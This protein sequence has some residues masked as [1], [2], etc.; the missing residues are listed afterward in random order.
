MLGPG[1]KAD[2]ETGPQCRRCRADLSLLFSLEEQRR[3]VLATA[4]QSA[5]RLQAHELTAA[6]GHAHRLRADADSLRLLALGHLLRRGFA[7]PRGVYHRP[8]R[9]SGGVGGLTFAPPAGPT[10]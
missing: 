9:A 6:A 1:C 4:Y 8:R 3:Q 7:P 2:V 10:G 5:D